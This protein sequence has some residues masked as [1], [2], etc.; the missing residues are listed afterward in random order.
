M[1]AQT[2]MGGK[3]EV[4]NG[5]YS[6]Q[7]LLM[8]LTGFASGMDVGKIEKSRVIPPLGAGKWL[9][10]GAFTERKSTGK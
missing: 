7:I 9:M 5:F 3:E 6:K 8:V 2:K 1:M 4:K 10:S